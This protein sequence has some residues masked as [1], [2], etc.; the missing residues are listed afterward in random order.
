MKICWLNILFEIKL[1]I[2]FI[3]INPAGMLKRNLRTKVE[4]AIETKMAQKPDSSPYIL[5][6]VATNNIIIS[7][8]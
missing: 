6:Q 2:F 3:K 1:Y 8:N 5:N 7:F 4:T